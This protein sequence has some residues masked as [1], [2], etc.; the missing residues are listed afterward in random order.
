MKYYKEEVDEMKGRTLEAFTNSYKVIIDNDCPYTIIEE[1]GNVVFAHNVEEMIKIDSLTTMICF[2]EELE[3]YEKC[4][5]LKK[6][7]DEIKRISESDMRPSS[8][9]SQ[10]P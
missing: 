3:E 4:A 9:V 5:K 7:K 6:F 1:Y 8:W 10:I 2:W